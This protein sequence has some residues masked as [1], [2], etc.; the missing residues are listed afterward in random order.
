MGG[1][2]VKKKEKTS[3][4]MIIAF[5]GVFTDY[6]CDL[7]QMYSQTTLIILMVVSGCIHRLLRRFAPRP[8]SQATEEAVNT[9]AKSQKY[10]L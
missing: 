4:R 3:L 8:P 10:K 1:L 9:T 6:F 7:M 2:S 5:A